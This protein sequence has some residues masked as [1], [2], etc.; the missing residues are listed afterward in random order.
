MKDTSI[1]MKQAWM[2]ACIVLV[3]VLLR[4]LYLNEAS[5]NPEFSHPIYDPEYNAYWARALATGDW[6][7]P[8]GIPDPEIRTT[9]HG[10]P[11]GYPW[12]LTGVYMLFGVNDFA[13][14]IIQMGIGV[15]NA[16]LLY[17]IGRKMFGAT[18]GFFAGMFMASYWVF[19]YFEGL[20]T[21]PAVAVFLLLALILTL[22]QWQD[23]LKLWRTVLFGMLIGGFAL[24]RPNGLLMMPFLLAWMTWLC[25]R[26]RLSFRRTASSLA[27]AVCACVCTLAPPFIRNY[28]VAGDI[29]F[30][31]SYG[32][33]NL[34][35][36][37]HPKASLVEPRIP[38]LMEIAGI[39]HWSCFD[40]PAIVRGLAAAQ[41]KESIKYS[42]ANRYF[43]R[44]AFTFI[45]EDPGRFLR[46]FARK[47]LLLF[48][49]HE[50]TNDTVM[51]YDKRYS[52]VLGKLPGFPWVLA[53]FLF[54]LF[55]FMADIPA[56]MRGEQDM[57]LTAGALL[58][59]IFCSYAFSVVIYFVAGRYRV[60]LIPIML[61]FAAF[62]AARLIDCF[63]HRRCKSA[64]AGLAVLMI[65]VPLAHHDFTG[66]K[67]SPGTWHLRRAMAYTAGG[68]VTR[69]RESYQRALDCGS[70][71]SVIFANL[72]RLHF[73]NGETQAGIDMYRACLSRNPNNAMIR[74]NL[75]YE[76][77]RLGRLK[78]AIEHLEQA[79]RINP[80]FALA[81][82]NLG[83]AL[84][85]QGDIEKA[86]HHF[87][88][89]ARLDPK[90]PAGPYNTARMLF[91][92]GD[93]D[94][95]IAQYLRTLE[96]NPAYASALNNLGY[97][98]EVRGAHEEALAYYR[99]AVEADPAFVLARNNLGN[100]LLKLDRPEEAKE[101]YTKALELEPGNP[102]TQY[103]LG[104]A[105]LA[106]DDLENAQ[107]Q[108]QQAMNLNPD[109]APTLYQLGILHMERGEAENAVEVLE[110]AAALSPDNTDIR[111][112][113]GKA[114]DAVAAVHPTEE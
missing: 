97:C 64:L 18:A 26:R 8:P 104:R 31:S 48:G 114:R 47:T 68:N 44:K 46:N 89:A 111:T 80:R 7:V 42:E 67:P 16:L 102:F 22:L 57:T 29:V 96:I 21:Y 13:P 36:G 109:F 81:H 113:L 59:L 82:I 45:K 50:I 105:L 99:R 12:F 106:L 87:R 17:F 83:N 19:P 79:V 30:L 54:G 110:K 14:R 28:I 2:P 63:R 9:P 53:L 20:L 58:L 1:L 92:Q 41:G 76:L 11:P 95:A 73:E 23:D 75:G 25:R 72:G 103:N 4:C 34:Y 70:Q 86:L 88:E 85:D 33:I 101:A 49:P 74:N 61:L 107:E 93:L 15:L 56:R 38:E 55:A 77:Y 40:Y 10:R 43:Y 5:G 62:G 65:L 66:Y 69:A 35:V 108:L 78:E 60:P 3:A 51:E 90:N 71:S 100:S 94:G 84:A 6:T 24:F 98:H 37:N 27:L 39:E 91:E 52:K 32:G 112:L